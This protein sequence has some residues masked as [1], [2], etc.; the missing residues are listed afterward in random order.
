MWQLWL[1]IC[2]KIVCKVF[3]I[4]SITF[5]TQALCEENGYIVAG[6][7]MENNPALTTVDPH[8]VV[9]PIEVK[10]RES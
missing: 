10:Q 3:L 7:I 4:T 2:S 9:D 5:P 1:I 8:C 6:Y